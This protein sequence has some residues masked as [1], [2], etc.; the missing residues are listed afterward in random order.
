[1]THPEAP[2]AAP[3]VLLVHALMADSRYQAG[4]ARELAARGVVAARLDLRGHGRSRWPDERRPDWRVDDYVERDLP[5]AV[6]ALG[7]R[8]YVLL[9]HS[10][11][12]I[13]S[14]AALA[15]RTIPAPRGLVLLGTTVW[16][17][18]GLGL[19]RWLRLYALLAMAAVCGRVP[20]R[21]L[22]LGPQDESQHL[23]SQ[24]HRWVRT[25][26]W[27]ADDGFDYQ[28]ALPGVTTPTLALTGSRD[29]Y[30]SPRE[31]ARLTDCLAGPV[32]RRTFEAD[33]FGFFRA[34]VLEG[35][36]DAIAAFVVLR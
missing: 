33:H 36:A 26:R 9:G 2:V 30:C 17:P 21:R 31:S 11:G 7:T 23:V 3:P 10:M 14:L 34:P 12:G 24:M 29:T 13:S 35:V 5:A 28:A 6:E 19:G 20:A 4:L 25:G 27:T 15:R 22:R 32:D 8:E 18:H 1:M 16:H